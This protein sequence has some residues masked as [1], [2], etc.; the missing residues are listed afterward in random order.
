ME[1]KCLKNY[2]SKKAIRFNESER[3]K[4]IKKN[5]MGSNVLPDIHELEDQAG[6]Q[7][8]NIVD[9]KL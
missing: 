6:D 7:S 8:K 4:T 5:Y 9:K 3:L 1:N 2:D